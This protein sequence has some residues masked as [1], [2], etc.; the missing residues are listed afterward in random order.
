MQI[1]CLLV[2]VSDLNRTRWPFNP[3]D[4]DRTCSTT[5]NLEDYFAKTSVMFFSFVRGRRGSGP[6]QAVT[7]ASSLA[8]SGMRL[9]VLGGDL[10]AVICACRSSVP[11]G[12]V[13]GNGAGPYSGAEPDEVRSLYVWGRQGRTE[14]PLHLAWRTCMLPSP[15]RSDRRTV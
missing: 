11:D 15:S 9:G 7:V 8:Q 2:Y 13:A 4:R 14:P 3:T 6:R 10:C 1:V 5:D 12:R